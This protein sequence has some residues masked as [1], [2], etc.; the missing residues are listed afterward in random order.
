MLFSYT[1]AA[2]YEMYGNITHVKY[3]RFPVKRKK[4]KKNAQGWLSTV[5]PEIFVS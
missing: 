2:A 3:S 1:E 4:E 5:I